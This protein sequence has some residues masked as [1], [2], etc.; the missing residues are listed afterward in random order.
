MATQAS[1]KFGGQYRLI[2]G[3]N[4]ASEGKYTLRVSCPESTG[5]VGEHT[6]WTGDYEAATKL[7]DYCQQHDALVFDAVR[8]LYFEGDPTQLLQ[9]V[10]DAH[11]SPVARARRRVVVDLSI[12]TDI[13]ES[14]NAIE[15]VT[16]RMAA[17][18]KM[19]GLSLS[20]I[21]SYYKGQ[22]EPPPQA[23]GIEFCISAVEQALTMK[24]HPELATQLGKEI[25]QLLAE[26]NAGSPEPFDLEEGTGSGRE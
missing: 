8:S 10:A 17:A 6:L 2:G 22:I 5:L 24:K 9:L 23:V 21:V 25:R 1:G 11:A 4:I 26:P 15:N 13:L 14:E 7:M 18:A 12:I 3:P 20:S 19:C 16:Q